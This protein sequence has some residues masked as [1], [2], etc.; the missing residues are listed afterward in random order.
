MEVKKTAR[1]PEGVGK[2]IVDAL[3]KQNNAKIYESVDSVNTAPDF[4]DDESLWGGKEDIYNE[5]DNSSLKEEIEEDSLKF[6]EDDIQESSENTE[7]FEA[8]NLLESEED[9]LE[10]EEETPVVIPEKTRF[11]KKE[12]YDFIPEEKTPVVIQPKKIPLVKASKPQKHYQTKVDEPEENVSTYN[13]E[14]LMRLISQLPSGVTRQTGAQIIRQTMEA[15]GISTNKM[16]GEAQQ[17]QEDIE[18]SIKNNMNKVEEYKTNVKILEKE[19]QKFKTQSDELEDLI[20]LF[21]LTEKES[22]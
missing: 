3:K 17:I 19:I 15:M 11:A 7:E 6:E 4:A 9:N 12:K 16:L 8:Y 5:E 21:I 1:L 18:R 13:V 2:K 14:V 20:S 10:Y 22:N